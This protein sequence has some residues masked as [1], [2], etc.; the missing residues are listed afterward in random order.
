M[1]YK[2]LNE[3]HI[4][5]DNQHTL[6][7]VIIQDPSCPKCHLL[8]RQSAEFK[9]F[10]SWYRNRQAVKTFSQRSVKIL[11]RYLADLNKQRNKNG[12]LT[13]EQVKVLGEQA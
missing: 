8:E 6:N 5:Y 1:A 11:D 3:F 9:Q 12:N 4:D 7:I 13:K 10:F 2:N